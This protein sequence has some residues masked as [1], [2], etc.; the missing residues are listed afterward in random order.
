M[1]DVVSTESR[2]SA[3]SAERPVASRR[4]IATM[5]FATGA[6]VANIY[7]VQPLAETLAQAFHSST[8]EVGLLITVL[9]LGYAV[10][11]ATLVPL[12]D[13]VERRRL[14]IVLLTGCA[15][16]LGF[17]ATAPNLA[18]IASAAVLVGLTSVA[19]QV[20]VPFA[21]HLAGEG[22]QG[23]VVGTVMSGLLIGI[24]L[25][26]TVSGLLAG[27]I[28]WRWVFGIAA[29]VTLAVAV[30]LWRELPT[31]PPTARMGYPALLRSVLRLI[32]VEPELRYRMLIGALSFAAFSAFWSTSGFLLARPPYHWNEIQ[33]G[34]FALLGAAGAM[35]AKFAG[36]LADAGY[37]RW[38]TIGFALLS[39]AS[40]LPLWI[41]GHSV[42]ALGIG[43]VLLDLGVQGL[44]ITNQSVIY[45][46]R[47][48]ARSRL[49]TA[50]M[51]TYF[52]GGTLGSGLASA[53]YAWFGWAGVCLLGASF[54]VL[55]A[56]LW[57]GE[58][59]RGRRRVR[60]LAGGY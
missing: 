50:Y 9:Q 13:L 26:R 12:G 57:L 29:L 58:Q 16:G 22:R 59:V 46:L 54:P 49:N 21:A 52:L 23:Q 47:A 19:V 42:V 48:D 36:K 2:V 30:V 38:S 6:V 45:A 1:L 37:A 25:S 3:G 17:M 31:H 5:A 41:G 56:L 4:V 18:V 10:G 55:V 7:Y 24:L 27:L 60:V 14:L 34:L 28:G 43:V 53:L 32:R 11:L 51:T 40:F 44:Q 8:G 20:I 15:V 33:I 35:A 39:T